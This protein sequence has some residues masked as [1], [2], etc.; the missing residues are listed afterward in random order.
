MRG[1]GR[2]PGLAAAALL[3]L[4]FAL[5]C[6]TDSY[7]GE[8][9]ITKARGDI[10]TIDQGAEAGLVVNMEVVVV[11]PPGEAVIHPVTGENLGN[12]EIE[13][14]MG[15]VTKTAA[16]SATVKIRKRPLLTIQSGDMVRFMTPEEEMIMDQERSMAREERAQEERRQIKSNVKELTKNIRNT[17]GAINSLKGAIGRLDRIDESIKVQ[18]RGINE[19]IHFMKEEIS[20]LKESVSLMGAVPV[21][22]Q[23][24]S[25]GAWIESEENV[26]ILEGIIR[27]VVDEEL[28]KGGAEPPT[29]TSRSPIEAST[30][31]K[32][33][34]WI[35]SE[36]T[37]AT[38]PAASVTVSWTWLITSAETVRSVETR[39]HSAVSAPTRKEPEAEV[40]ASP[41]VSMSTPAGEAR[42]RGIALSLAVIV[43]PSI[44]S[45]STCTL[46]V[47]G[48][49][50][51]SASEL[52]SEPST[53]RSTSAARSLTAR[54]SEE[55]APPITAPCSRVMVSSAT[56]ASAS[57]CE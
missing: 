47:P 10:L 21:S 44:V 8:A 32:A 24:E 53:T 18:L 25:S 16:R 51:M 6:A 34:T 45:V 50:E 29:P 42:V 54:V 14:V 3:A 57:I 15:E 41:S 33:L 7:A 43:D 12:P 30:L 39:S 40:T 23:E 20:A 27:D 49:S 38:S 36:V 48:V 28:S 13:I 1:F 37:L 22:D 5:T 46:P 11:R 26:E 4:S 2:T 19:D 9:F 35:R 52:I 31:S 17:Q 55:R 56:S